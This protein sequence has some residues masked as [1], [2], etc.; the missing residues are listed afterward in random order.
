MQKAIEVEYW[1]I[2]ED[3]V[4]SR[5]GEL[6]DVSQYVEEEFVQPLV[7]LKTPPCE[8]YPEL[9]RTFLEQMKQLLERAEE[10]NKLL[11]PFG[12]PVNSA[13]IDQLPAERTR[14]Q[15]AVI[16]D[17]FDYA[18][19]CAGTHLHFEQRNV[20]DQLNVLIALDP[21]LALLNSSPYFEGRPIASSAR[22]LLY[23]KR[24]YEYF[25]GHGQ[26]WEY[27]ETVA[28]WEERLDERFEAF[29]QA[30]VE[31]GIDEDDIT[32]NFS[33]DTAVWTPV[34]LRE[35][36]PT[37]EWRSPDVSLPSQVLHLVEDMSA[38]MEQV[39]DSVVSIGG[40]AGG[41]TQDEITLPKFDTA[42]KY[43][44]EAIQHG[45]DS[46]AVSAYLQRMGF[47]T[48]AYDPLTREIGGQEYVSLSDARKLR[49]EYGRRLKQDVD[50]LL[51]ARYRS[52]HR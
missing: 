41:R 43:T 51:G 48:A 20:T 19:H 42:W 6:T 34:R 39:S 15:D 24:C 27:V 26:L 1:V 44:D 2:D 37:V 21:A 7:E 36:M 33:P 8:T 14:I 50:A 5:P 32:A 18:N 10:L 25:P 23:R 52:L 40:T 28:E 17:E 45:L 46:R 4:L 9:K 35:A 49:V 31:A 16:G 47:D 29:K 13:P 12:T 3:G 22:S 38:I 11:V 30:A